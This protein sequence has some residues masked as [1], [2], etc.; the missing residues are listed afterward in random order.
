MSG[1][2]VVLLPFPLSLFLEVGELLLSPIIGMG[3]IP[4][5]LVLGLGM[6]GISEVGLAVSFVIGVWGE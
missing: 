2:G 4:R 6:R 3:R 1:V 5:E